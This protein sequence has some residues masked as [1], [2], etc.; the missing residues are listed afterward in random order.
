MLEVSSQQLSQASAALQRLQ[1]EATRAAAAEA[2][3]AGHVEQIQL[4]TQT[5]DMM[6]R[7]VPERPE[8]AR[9]EAG[10]GG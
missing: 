4:L 10:K 9:G 7:L 6:R 1:S 2:A 3:N 8:A 5:V